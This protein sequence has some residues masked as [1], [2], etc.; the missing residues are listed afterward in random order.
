MKTKPI[1][2]HSAHVPISQEW[3]T[4]KSGSCLG[5]PLWSPSGVPTC[6]L[7]AFASLL[8]AWRHLSFLPLIWIREFTRKGTHT[9]PYTLK[10]LS[11]A[12]QRTPSKHV[13][14]VGASPLRSSEDKYLSD[15]LN[16]SEKWELKQ[17]YHNHLWGLFTTHMQGLT[18]NL[19]ESEFLGEEPG[20]WT[21]KKYPRWF[22]WNIKLEN[23]W[24]LPGADSSSAW[25]VQ[26][27]ETDGP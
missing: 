8:N 24:I 3:C 2:Q 27:E 14:V 20:I 6:L 1:W 7:Y 25:Q 10:G 16:N 12:E 18:S 13:L 11:H 5:L 19:R 17:L 22:S 23:Y 21:L 4:L 15:L 26:L 9:P